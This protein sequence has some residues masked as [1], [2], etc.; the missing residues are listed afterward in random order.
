[1]VRS[2]WNTS[3][4][5]FTCFLAVF[6]LFKITIW[7]WRKINDT[8]CCTYLISNCYSCFAQEVWVETLN[9]KLSWKI[10][11]QM[12]NNN[13]RTVFTDCR[14]VPLAIEV[15]EVKRLDFNGTSW[16]L[17]RWLRQTAEPIVSVAIVSISWWPLFS[18]S[19]SINRTIR[20]FTVQWHRRGDLDARAAWS[21]AFWTLVR[22]KGTPAFSFHRNFIQKGLKRWINV[23]KQNIVTISI[24]NPITSRSYFYNLNI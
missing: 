2:W 3:W 14:R 18:R 1:M 7:H 16:S 20:D 12:R 10:L 6:R 22:F 17:T 4:L 24:N 8:Y 15:R 23:R 19:E 13:K 21:R 11:Q 9:Q 5:I